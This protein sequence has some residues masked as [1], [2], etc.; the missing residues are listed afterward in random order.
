[1]STVATSRDSPNATHATRTQLAQDGAP[2]SCLPQNDV[3]LTSPPLSN[4]CQDPAHGITASHFANGPFSIDNYIG[5]EDKTCAPEG[6]A[7]PVE[8]RA[9]GLTR[10][11]S[12]WVHA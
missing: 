1:M 12:G 11:C 10:R 2:Y 9:E 3:N 6:T 4:T 8:R 5:P 7:A